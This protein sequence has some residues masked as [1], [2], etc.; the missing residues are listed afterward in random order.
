MFYVS[1]Y[2]YTEKSIVLQFG[3]MC[4]FSLNYVVK[5]ESELYI[6]RNNLLS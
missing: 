3:P 6:T 4:E 1:L 5:Y 2:C